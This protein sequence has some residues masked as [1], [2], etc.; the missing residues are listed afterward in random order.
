MNFSTNSI[1]FSQEGGNSVKDQLKDIIGLNPV[2][3]DLKGLGVVVTLL[4]V[5]A[6]LGMN[7][8]AAFWS[9]IAFWFLVPVG[10]ITLL[11]AFSH[12]FAVPTYNR[13]KRAIECG[14]I[15][16]DF[17]VP[18]K[19]RRGGYLVIDRGADA[20]YFGGEMYRLSDLRDVGAGER[21]HSVGSSNFSQGTLHLFF[22]AGAKPEQVLSMS[23][24]EQA[25]QEELRIRNFMGW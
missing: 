17:Y 13:I 1:P 2:V 12:I 18:A 15:Q 20:I 22:R 10:I 25:R 7:D 21:S 11:F 24:H 8:I 14:E 4:I 9:L 3:R 19:Y 23:T 16:V 5:S 6:A